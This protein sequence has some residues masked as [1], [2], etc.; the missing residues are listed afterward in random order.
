[1][2]HICHF[3]SS[4]SNSD[5]RIFEKECLSLIDNGY[6]VTL[7]AP[8]DTKVHEGVNIVGVKRPNK[9]FKRLLITPKLVYNAVSE[10]EADLYHFHDPE[11]IPYARKL[12]RKGRLVVF[13]CHE[14]IFD[15]IKDKAW[16]PN[17]IKPLVSTAFNSY[18]KRAISE[19]NAVI[20]VDSLMVEKISKYAQHS[21][22]VSN[23]PRL[24]KV[25]NVNRIPN[26]I[27]F[28]GGINE[29]WC[30]EIVVQ[31]IEEIED[32]HY[33]LCGK[34][35]SEY[36]DRLASY[37]GWSK[38]DYKGVVAHDEA[39]SVLE[40]ASIGIALLKFNNNVFEKR[41]TQGNTKIYEE[42]AAG[43]PIICSS[44]DVWKDMIERYECG[45][46]V[47]PESVD[48]VRDA[49]VFLMENPLIAQAMGV[50]ARRAVEKE[51]SWLT[52]EKNLLSLYDLLL[53]KQQYRD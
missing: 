18:I 31:A 2:C 37:S 38:V 40:H 41:G 11:M 3:T 34:S 32:A 53:H 45:I 52:Q 20:S 14:N 36:L 33:V 51:Y 8:G 50:R 35:S 25:K 16:I 1:M 39:E 9:R 4:H 21:V 24:K 48:E 26:T 47:N 30:H 46:C 44:S 28:A 5:V 17:L 49:I 13:D 12:A 23:H 6:K 22:L 29:M 19:F 43:L 15:F 7:V 27:A 42:M 10:I